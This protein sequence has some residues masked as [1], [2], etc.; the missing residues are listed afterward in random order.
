MRPDVWWGVHI[1][2]ER[3]L[4]RGMGIRTLRPQVFLGKLLSG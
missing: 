1:V 4:R 2:P 3:P